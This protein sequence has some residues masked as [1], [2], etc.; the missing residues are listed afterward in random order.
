[1]PT[2][3]QLPAVLNTAAARVDRVGEQLVALHSRLVLIGVS[4][5]FGWTGVARTRFGRDVQALMKQITSSA[6]MTAALA[7]ILR[8]ASAGATSR[9]QAEAAAAALAKR[10]AEEAARQRAAA[11]K[12]AGGSR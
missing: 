12:Q 4:M 9:L 3:P 6:Q 10:Q 8:A 1:M 2:D 7:G 11:A 5:T